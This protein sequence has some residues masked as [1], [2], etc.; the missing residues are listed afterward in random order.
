MTEDA[1]NWNGWISAHV[2]GDYVAVFAAFVF[3]MLFMM[4]AIIYRLEFWHRVNVGSVVFLGVVILL[5][6]VPKLQSLTL[7]WGDAELIGVVQAEVRAADAAKL[8]E[9]ITGAE[10]RIIDRIAA[11]QWQPP[12][13]VQPGGNLSA[14]VQPKAD[15]R[16]EKVNDNKERY[17]VKLVVVARPSQAEALKPISEGLDAQGYSVGSAIGPIEVKGEKPPGTVRIV[18]NQEYSQLSNEVEGQLNQIIKANKLDLKVARESKPFR[19]RNGDV[20]LQIF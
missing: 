14:I 2:L 20:Q 13:P 11:L 4:G 7:K 16:F 12:E 15:K 10:K 1:A 17:Q 8:D 5:L 6:M 18:Y 19:V 9:K 3:L